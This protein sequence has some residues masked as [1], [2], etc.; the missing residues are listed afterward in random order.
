[1]LAAALL[2][3][4]AGWQ[5]ATAAANDAA[6]EDARSRYRAALDETDRLLRMRLFAD[7]EL[8]WRSL[9][10]ANPEAPA[11]QTDWGNAALGAQQG[12]RAVL[13]YRRALRLAPDDARA[14]ANLAWLR[15]RQPLWLP[16]PSASG[17]LDSLLFWRQQFNVAQLFCAGAAAFAVGLLLLAPWS[18]QRPRWLR[19]LAAPFLLAWAALS[20]TAL[21]TDDQRSAGVLLAD[22]ATLRSADSPGAS[23]AFA[24][25]LPAGAEVDVLEARESW[26]R[27]ALADG[28]SGWLPSASVARVVAES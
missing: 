27:V 2:V 7:A 9:A 19:S 23:P 26:L 28:T 17:T 13:A 4:W 3:G 16:R 5:P 18:R 1:M 20:A 14:R 22:G 10:E 15:D 12:G 8:A 11:I 6:L 25:P 24:N 21:A